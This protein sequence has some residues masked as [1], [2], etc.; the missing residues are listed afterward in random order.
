MVDTDVLSAVVFVRTP[1]GRLGAAVAAPDPLTRSRQANLLEEQGRTAEAEQVWGEAVAAGDRFA[2][3][4]LATLL[5]RLGR[6]DEAEQ[7]EHDPSL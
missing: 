4:R 3:F 1:G 7:A 6:A 2:R 5:E